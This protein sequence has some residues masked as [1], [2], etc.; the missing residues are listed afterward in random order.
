MRFCEIVRDH[1]VF[2]LLVRVMRVMS[3]LLVRVMRVSQVAVPR[4]VL[5]GTALGSSQKLTQL[6]Q[7][8]VTWVTVLY[9]NVW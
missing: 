3:D 4:V 7:T 6:M 2:D 8:W 1:D 9:S 5:P